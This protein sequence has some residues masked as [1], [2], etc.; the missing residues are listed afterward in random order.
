LKLEK[1]MF[2]IKKLP[3]KKQLKKTAKEHKGVDPTRT[4]FAFQFL[5]SA[6]EAFV[7]IDRF[8]SEKNLSQ[9]RFHALLILSEKKEGL[10]SFELAEEMGV[11]RATASGLIKGLSTASFV[12]TSKSDSDGRMKKIVITEKGDEVLKDTAPQYYR[13]LSEISGRIDKKT[14]KQTFDIFTEISKNTNR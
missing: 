12:E 5:R 7:M 14:V 2:L 11:S 4:V 3:E 8:F 10:Y 6:S 13:M 1:K 9:A